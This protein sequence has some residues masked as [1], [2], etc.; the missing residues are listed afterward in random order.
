MGIFG[1]THGWG[2]QKVP[3]PKICHTYPTMTKLGTVIAYLK[4]IQKYMD[5]VTQPLTSADISIFSPEISKFCYIKKYRYR[6]YFSFSWVFKDLLINLVKI[7][8][9]WAKMTTP[10]LLKITVFWNKG[11]DVITSVDDIINKILS[12]DS[13]Y[14]VDV[15][16]W[17]KFGNCS[18]SMSEVITTLTL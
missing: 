9:M 4:K 7:L 1:A 15:L 16:M 6:L 8:M 10:G 11:Y 5:H 12:H 3:L 14:I 2:G 18:M 17:P 13:N